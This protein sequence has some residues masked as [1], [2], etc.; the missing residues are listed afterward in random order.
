MKLTY[1]KY[2]GPGIVI[3]AYNNSPSEARKLEYIQ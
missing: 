1:Q 3:Q 2:F